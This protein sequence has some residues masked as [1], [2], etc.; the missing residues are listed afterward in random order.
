M[1]LSIE[2]WLPDKGSNLGPTD[3][4]SVAL[5][6]ELSGSNTLDYHYPVEDVK[7]AVMFVGAG[8]E[9]RPYARPIPHVV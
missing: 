6:T 4:E 1:A 5:P 7:G 3:P 2:V 9:T 8:T